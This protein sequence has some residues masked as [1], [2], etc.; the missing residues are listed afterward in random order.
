[1]LTFIGKRL[2][3]AV[4]LGL[5]SCATREV[6]PVAMVQSGDDG[7]SCADLKRQISDD[8][9][10]Q[11]EYQRKDRQVEANNVAKN[12]GAVIPFVGLA[13]AASTDLSNE[14]QVKARAL[15]DRIERLQ[16]LEKQKG[17]GE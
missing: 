11:A 12:V 17:C 1:M 13:L 3:L 14:E 8:T 15:G 4:A 5:C 7:L 10:A 16:Y 6:A 2:L 9:A